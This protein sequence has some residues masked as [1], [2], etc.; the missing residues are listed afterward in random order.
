MLRGASGNSTSPKWPIRQIIEEAADAQ[1]A[2]IDFVQ[3]LHVMLVAPAAA[4]HAHFTANNHSDHTR[5]FTINNS[6]TVPPEVQLKAW[7]TIATKARCAGA[8]FML[9]LQLQTCAR[10]HYT[11]KYNSQAHRTHFRLLLEIVDVRIVQ[12]RTRRV[13]AVIVRGSHDERAHSCCAHL[14]LLLPYCCSVDE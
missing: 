8:D 5:L 9:K 11:L 1:V 3:I 13:Y 7:T 10:P 12:T 14:C 2:R 6:A 4:R